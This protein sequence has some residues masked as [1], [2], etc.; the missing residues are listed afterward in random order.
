M[1]LRR[2]GSGDAHASAGP[3]LPWRPSRPYQ[4]LKT[5]A[6][7]LWEFLHKN[8]GRL[9]LLLALARPVWTEDSSVVDPGRL[10]VVLDDSRSM[11][12]AHSGGKSRYEWA[13]EAVERLTRQVEE[14]EGAEVRVEEKRQYRAER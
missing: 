3:A 11:S 7:K 4:E 6:R 14:G 1:Y 8:L 13:R 5:R 9:A 10:A 2:A 12:L